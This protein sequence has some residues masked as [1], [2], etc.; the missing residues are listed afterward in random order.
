[1]RRAIAV[2]GLQWGLIP[3][4]VVLAVVLG[5]IVSSA[6]LGRAQNPLAV[7]V[8]GAVMFAVAF[9]LVLVSDRVVRGTFPSTSELGLKGGLRWR[10]WLYG[11]GG[12]VLYIIAV[13]GAFALA[14]VIFPGVDWEQG[15]EVGIRNGIVGV[16]R[17]FAFVA[18]VV[19]APIVEE[20]LFRGYLFSR[21]RSVQM[22][23]WATIGI[24][25][26]VFAAV[27]LQ[28][29]VGLDVFILS[30]VACILRHLTGSVWPGTIVHMAKNLIAFY[31][32]FVLAL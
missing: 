18:L 9:T 4:G 23:L 22:P 10:D 12:L 13:M 20:V 3:L 25:S 21:L 15:Q 32:V 30:V 26:I 16:D 19:V 29:N 31:I 1:M 27:H 14:K 8:S 7:L 24:V 5:A 6:L 28:I 2:R 17:L 11:V